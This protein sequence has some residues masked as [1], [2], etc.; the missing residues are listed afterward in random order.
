[1]SGR[2]F[3]L[4]KQWNIL[5]LKQQCHFDERNHHQISNDLCGWSWTRSNIPQRKG[6]RPSM[7]DPWGDETS[8]TKDIDSDQQHHSGGSNQQ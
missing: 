3:F 2:T 7:T 4:I 8:P 5:P 1:L 6:S